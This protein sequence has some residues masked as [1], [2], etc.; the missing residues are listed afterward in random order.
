[1][2]KM[3]VSDIDGTLLP[4]ATDQMPQEMYEVIRECKKRGILFVAASGR[5]YHS[6]RYVLEPVAD[7]ILFLAENGSLIFEKNEIIYSQYIQP[8]IARELL[9]DM[10]NTQTGEVILSTPY[11]TYLEKTGEVY[12]RVGRPDNSY[13]S[14]TELVN[15]LMPYC[16]RTNK[17]AILIKEN[18]EEVARAYSEKYADS[19]NCKRAGTV[20]LDCMAKHADKGEAVGI[21]QKRFGIK[22][23]ETMAFGD[24]L[25]DL[26]MLMA[27][28]ENYA[29]ADGNP[30]LIR[31]AKYT[32]PPQKDNGVIQVIREK[33]LCR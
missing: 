4:E 14:K 24:N 22:K 16:S 27:A 19:L 29:M 9:T 33:V 30:E 7:D 32:A 18:L 3:I 8:E 17:M 5:Q 12:E 6:M 25:N 15:D 21:L 23:E 20:W 26:G 13:H 1:M 31:R 10:R 2:I 28:G 11:V